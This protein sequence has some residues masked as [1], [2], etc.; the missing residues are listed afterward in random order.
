MMAAETPQIGKINQSSWGTADT[1]RGRAAAANDRARAGAKARRASP[2]WRW[3]A[4]MNQIQASLGR[5]M[6]PLELLLAVMRH[7]AFDIRIRLKAAILAAPFCHK[8]LPPYR[9]TDMIAP[10]F[11]E[12]TSVPMTV[13]ARHQAATPPPPEPVA[14]KPRRPRLKRNQRIS[15]VIKQRAA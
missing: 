1:D 12:P 15:K 13:V 8:K 9:K 6:R 10:V 7:K 2:N 5:K 4:A 3:I 11:A 14:P